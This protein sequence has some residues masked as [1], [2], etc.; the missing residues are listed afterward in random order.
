MFY[1]F[2]QSINETN[3][4]TNKE[5]NKE[6]KTYC[7]ILKFFFGVTM[8]ILFYYLILIAPVAQLVAALDW[9]S[10][11][12]WFEPGREHS[13]LYIN[14]RDIDTNYQCF[15][16]LINQSMKQTNKQTKKQT[17]KERHIVLFLNF[18]L[19]LPWGSYFITL[20]W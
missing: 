20:Y 10:K 13:F 6:R 18:F 1:L 5:T 11:G 2:N 9:R 17:K 8:G 7:F 19:V 4:Q 15:I 14:E 16:Y 3:K 12:H